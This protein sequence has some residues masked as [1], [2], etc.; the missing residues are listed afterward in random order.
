MSKQDYI[1]EEMERRGIDLVK[2]GS[3]RTK[4]YLNAPERYLIPKDYLEGLSDSDFNDYLKAL[5]RVQ[6]ENAGGY[7]GWSGGLDILERLGFKRVEEHVG[8]RVFVSMK[9]GLTDD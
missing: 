4:R 6:N 1:L 8:H 5:Y 7:D 9:W 3:Y 2:H